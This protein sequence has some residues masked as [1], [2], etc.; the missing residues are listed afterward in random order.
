MS[1]KDTGLEGHNET[2]QW[3]YLIWQIKNEKYKDTYDYH[4]YKAVFKK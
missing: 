1:L 4:Y 3:N 2:M